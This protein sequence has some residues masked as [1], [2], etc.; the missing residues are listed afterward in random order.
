MVRQIEIYNLL[1]IHFLSGHVLVFSV[2][3]L[4]QQDAIATVMTA[5]HVFGT[6]WNVLSAFGTLVDDWTEKLHAF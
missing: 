3:P 6:Q 2:S 4:L 1:I 5:E